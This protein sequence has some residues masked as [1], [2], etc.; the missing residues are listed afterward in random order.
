MQRILKTLDK[1]HLLL[2]CCSF[3]KSQSSIQKFVNNLACYTCTHNFNSLQQ[4]GALQPLSIHNKDFSNQY[5][6]KMTKI[7]FPNLT[8]EKEKYTHCLRMLKHKIQDQTPIGVKF[9]NVSFISPK[10]V[11]IEKFFF[12]IRTMLFFYK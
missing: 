7:V 2:T 5:T 3:Q 4:F 12:N 10:F 8:C 1:P 6:K 11:A 9:V